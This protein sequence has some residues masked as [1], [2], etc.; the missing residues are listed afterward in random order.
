[1][2]TA[3]EQKKGS[4]LGWLGVLILLWIILVVAGLLHAPWGGA[5]R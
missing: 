1:M 2:V 5:G 3:L 4:R